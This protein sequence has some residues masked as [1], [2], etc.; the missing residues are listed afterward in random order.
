MA[1]PALASVLAAGQR[2]AIP[3]SMLAIN[4]AV[5]LV[6]TGGFAVYARGQ[7]WSG[8]WA[9]GVGLM[10]GLLT[11][12]VR[13]LSDSLAT[14][15]MLGGLMLWERRRWWAAGLL[16]LGVLSREPMLLAVLAIIVASA[17]RW[18]GIRREP[19]ALVRIVRAV[20]PV[21]MIPA[22][23]YV[24]WQSYASVRYGGS[25]ASPGSAYRLPFVGV[26]DEVRH[27]LDDSS[28]RST[29]WD[30]AYLGLMMAGIVAALR[31]VILQASAAGVA[32]L[33]FGLG[34]LVL[35]F[36]DPWSYTRLSAPLFATLLLGGLQRSS[37]PA[38]V[39]CVAAAA[40]TV[41]L[42]FTPWFR[43]V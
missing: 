16:T 23:A 9:L 10:A 8:W 38:L 41:V 27:A 17:A 1:Y 40:L 15:S 35:V 42:P 34:L 32:A 13:D 28:R 37:R 6:A 31:L 7:G 33:L 30:L 11:A 18:W 22:L 24:V 20:W 21:V 19:G 3:W 39:V 43:A 25:V 29:A 4:V 5:A 2:T 12:T 36:G 26:L 14:V